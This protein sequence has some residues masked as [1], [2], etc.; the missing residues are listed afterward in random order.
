MAKELDTGDILAQEAIAIAPEE[1]ARELRPRLIQLGAKLLADTLPRYL[2]GDA[3]LTP[4]DASHA[5]Y[6]RKLK[7]EDGLL[8]LSAPAEE[9]WNKYRAY[10]DTIG[11]YFFVNGKR[12]KIVKASYKNGTFIIERV[13]PEGKREMEYRKIGGY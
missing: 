11:T 10:A 8:S 13:I 4:Q 7:K 6:A 3:I 12:V 9:N 1:T 5:S 2:R